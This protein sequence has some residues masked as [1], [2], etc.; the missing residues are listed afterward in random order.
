MS[1]T[2]YLALKEQT[3]RKPLSRKQLK[4]MVAEYQSFHSEWMRK[5]EVV[6]ERQRAN[7]SHTAEDAETG[8]NNADNPEIQVL[9]EF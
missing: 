3:K 2:E 5:F 4:A 7:V 8:N 9:N 1:S 6:S